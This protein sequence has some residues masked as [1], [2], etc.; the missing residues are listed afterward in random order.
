MSG[1]ILKTVSSWRTGGDPGRVGGRPAGR[2]TMPLTYWWTSSLPSARPD[3]LRRSG[4][5]CRCWSF[6]GVSR[7]ERHV[8]QEVSIS[9][10]VL[11]RLLWIDDFWLLENPE[12]FGRFTGFFFQQR[13]LGILRCFECDIHFFV[14]YCTL[15]LTYFYWDNM[16]YESSW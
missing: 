14:I 2:W 1:V 11:C 7:P 10:P 4:F 15:L 3:H 6:Y 12:F 5:T 13:W 8:H 9:S 16:F